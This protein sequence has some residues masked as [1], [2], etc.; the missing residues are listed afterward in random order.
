MDSV[1]VDLVGYILGRKS[2]E[3]KVVLDSDNYSFTDD[4]EGNIV[5]AEEE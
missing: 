4:G 3:G 1:R 5:I 2:G